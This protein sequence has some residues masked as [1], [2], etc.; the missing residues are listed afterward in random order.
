MT[1]QVLIGDVVHV[2]GC[3]PWL[4]EFGCCYGFRGVDI[5]EVKMYGAT[6]GGNGHFVGVLQVIHLEGA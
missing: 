1:V 4:G 3:W 6:H 5:Y 2:F